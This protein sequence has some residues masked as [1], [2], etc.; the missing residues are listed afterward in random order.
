M[1]F[2]RKKM[3]SITLYSKV[4]Q[5]K[6]IT[7]FKWRL[8]TRNIRRVPIRA[9]VFQLIWLSSAS[10]LEAVLRLTSRATPHSGDWG[11][12]YHSTFTHHKSQGLTRFPQNSYYF[13]SFSFL[14][15]QTK[16]NF[17]TKF[18]FN[19]RMSESVTTYRRPHTAGSALTVLRMSATS[20]QYAARGKWL[21]LQSVLLGHTYTI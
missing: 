13:I 10:H 21:L 14:P 1:F 4:R 3:L 5:L 8:N 17:V 2:N 18:Y 6:L 12:G 9:T 7:I 20:I 19:L 15:L 16:K 11:H